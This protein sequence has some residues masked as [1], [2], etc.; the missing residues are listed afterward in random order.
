M[1]RRIV[2]ADVQ[3]GYLVFLDGLVWLE[4]VRLGHTSRAVYMSLH[5]AA[6]A[7]A[8]HLTD[9]SKA[10][11]ECLGTRSVPFGLAEVVRVV[12]R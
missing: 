5:P 12:R 7:C 9:R 1:S 8:C 10:D 3:R 6:C 11:H 4:V 2:A